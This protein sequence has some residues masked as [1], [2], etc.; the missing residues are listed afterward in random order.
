MF[1]CFEYISIN[2]IINSLID[3]LV[4]DNLPINYN[5]YDSMIQ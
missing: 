1:Y 2:V 5:D 3:Q 4:N